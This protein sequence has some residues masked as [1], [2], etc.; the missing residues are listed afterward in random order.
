MAISIDQLTQN[1]KEPRC[2]YTLVLA[3]AR[4]AAE[5]NSGATALIKTA[6]KKPSTI[7]MEEFRDG[8]VDFAK[9]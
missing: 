6:S 7:A 2:Y 4:R 8:K 1:C 3:M 5:L 9:E